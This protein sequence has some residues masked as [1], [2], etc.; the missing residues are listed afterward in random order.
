MTDQLKEGSRALDV[1]SGSGYLTACMSYMVGP[2]GKVIGVE[3]IPELVEIGMRNVR[4]DCPEFI[5]DG[6][7]Q[8]V[9]RHPDLMIYDFPR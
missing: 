2:T 6:R 8:F 4:E 7:V 3:H 1:G 9:G 5:S